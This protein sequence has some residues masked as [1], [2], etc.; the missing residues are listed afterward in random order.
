LFAFACLGVGDPVSCLCSACGRLRNIDDLDAKVASKLQPPAVS[1]KAVATIRNVWRR[2][3]VEAKRGLAGEALAPEDWEVPLHSTTKNSLT[4]K[5]ASAY[6]VVLRARKMPCDSLLGRIFR[7]REKQAL[8]AFPLG[9]VRSLAT[10][11]QIK[12]RHQL[13]HGV[14]LEHGVDKTVDLSMTL[15]GF[16]LCLCVLLNAYVIVG[17]DGWCPK[18]A[19]EDYLDL[20]EEKL[21]HPNSPGLHVV[22]AVDLQH[23]IRWVDLIRGPEGVTLGKAIAQ[24][25]AELAG[26]WQ[27]PPASSDGGHGESYKKRLRNE[28]PKRFVIQ[29]KKGDKEICHVWNKGKCQDT[30][31]NGRLHVCDVRGCGQYHR[32]V[33]KHS[34]D[35]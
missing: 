35:R 31:P 20:V 29:E 33:D 6:G 22:A 17:V 23:R 2:C 15:H 30:C 9:R 7:E 4:S 3:E 24:S 34:A 19:A 13:G 27:F 28:E 5:C 12:E 18:Q 11:P 16:W 26:A 21:W 25:M 10:T 8:T 32:R 1:L 14:V